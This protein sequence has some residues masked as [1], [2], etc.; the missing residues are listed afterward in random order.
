MP[1]GRVAR[2]SRLLPAVLTLVLVPY[3]IGWAAEP[4][5]VPEA[6]PVAGGSAGPVVDAP[7]DLAPL[8]ARIATGSCDEPG[9][10]TA[11]L[12]EAVTGASSDAVGEAVYASISESEMS[13]ADLSGP[14]RALFVG[15]SDLEGAVACGAFG[16]P[17]Q[18]PADLAIGL[19]PLHDSTY[20]GT[21]LFHG[22]DGRLTVYLVVVGPGA[23]GPAASGSPEPSPPPEAAASPDASGLSPVR[24]AQPGTS[25]APPF[26]PLPG[27]SSPA[28]G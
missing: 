20:S 21:A 7:G 16:G 8:P 3:A 5:G 27:P 9:D 1:T 15:G 17:P 25:G 28:G 14:D 26:S 2:T 11:D 22:S 19:L 18:G 4:L 10:V 6:S 23:A 12:R 24:S 13:L